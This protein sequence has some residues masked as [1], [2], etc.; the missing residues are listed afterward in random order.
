M[1][2]IFPPALRIALLLG[3]TSISLGQAAPPAVSPVH[4]AAL[5]TYVHG[6]TD[7]LARQQVGEQGIPELLD[8]LLDPRFP[9]RDNIVAFLAHLAG[10]EA[11]ASLLHC[12][13]EP[14]GDPALP[15]EDRALLLI[16]QALG[17]IASRDGETAL[18][19]LLAMTAPGSDGG[20]LALAVERGAFPAAMRND[21]IEES[22]RGLALSGRPA[23]TERL[24]QLATGV[25][26]VTGLPLA[27]RATRAIRQASAPERG[28]VAAALLGGTSDTTPI[29]HLHG[30]SFANH[31]DTPSKMTDSALD[32]LFDDASVLIGRGDFAEDVYC[33]NALSRLGTAGSFGTTGDGLDR[34]DDQSELNT[35]LFAGSQRVKVVRAINY[36]GGPGSNIVGCASRPG[37]RMVVVRI[38]GPEDALW[39]HE[40]GH[41]TGLGHNADSRFVMHG[42]LSNSA[43]GVSQ[44]ECNQYHFPSSQTGATLSNLGSCHD[45]DTD[46]L[47]S[48]IDN[49]PD[50]ANPDQADADDDGVGDV[51]DG[52]VDNDLDGFGSPADAS[53]S[54]GPILDC[55]DTRADVYPNAPDL[56]DGADND[57]DLAVDEAMCGDFDLDG[58]GIGGGEL[59]WLGRAH[60]E[61]SVTPAVEWWFGA[62]Y[63]LDGCVDGNDL[64]VLGAVW[65][66]QAGA[67]L[68]P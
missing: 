43:S 64:A 58:L 56:C 16:P 7:E 6:M 47:I 30:L 62:D 3:A 4:E 20:R 44:T 8:L 60:G 55:D 66:C 14:P 39:A 53:C 26:V 50:H 42:Q 18:A 22:L 29:N 13:D 27:E 67:P 32:A 31:V 10:D 33:C 40:Y 19:A 41:N 38:S 65:G 23:A 15:D 2:R 24:E 35:V 45:N 54:A 36:C 48:T 12:L 17:R 25:P 34:I 63:T 68:C 49:C 5:L 59:A 11:T 57:C 37:S 9:R 51:C 52:C 61:C 1:N 28:D 21:L 46:D